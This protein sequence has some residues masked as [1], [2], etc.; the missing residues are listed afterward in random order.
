MRPEEYT[1]AAICRRMELPGF[2][3]LNLP[4]PAVREGPSR[5]HLLVLGTPEAR[6]DFFEQ[7]ERA[8]GRI[9]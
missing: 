2:V 1:A 4:M 3:D 5:T 7:L 6:A 8:G 9:W